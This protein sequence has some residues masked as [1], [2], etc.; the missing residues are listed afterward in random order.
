MS[1]YENNGLIPT[2]SFTNCLCAVGWDE[3]NQT[4]FLQVTPW[5][6]DKPR[7]YL[8]Q[9]R[10]EYTNLEIFANTARMAGIELRKRSPFGILDQL[11]ADQ[12]QDQLK[13]MPQVSNASCSTVEPGDKFDGWICR[14]TV[15]A[16]EPAE[17]VAWEPPKTFIDK[18]T[19]LQ[20]QQ[21]MDDGTYD[22]KRAEWDAANPGIYS[23]PILQPDENHSPCG[24][25][26]KVQHDEDLY[27]EGDCVDCREAAVRAALP[28][29]AAVTHAFMQHVTDMAHDEK[30]YDTLDGETADIVYNLGRGHIRPGQVQFKGFMLLRIAVEKFKALKEQ[31]Y[32]DFGIVPTTAWSDTDVFEVNYPDNIQVLVDRTEAGEV[33]ILVW[34]IG[35][36]DSLSEHTT[37][38]PIGICGKPNCGSLAYPTKTE[39]YVACCESCCEDLYSFEFEPFDKP[40]K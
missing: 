27:P 36:D 35:D 2:G 37:K 38:L 6:S 29:L 32:S 4:F 20:L 22:A 28:D 40:A 15:S 3:R 5:G 1:R 17:P 7:H 33:S 21:M 23:T 13:Q 8:G 34:H 31:H 12:I 30:F 11:R 16:E 26:G 18:Y 24:Q 25:C 19:S 14:S 9:T 10:H 39:G